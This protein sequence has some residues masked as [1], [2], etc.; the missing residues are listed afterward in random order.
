MTEI[1]YEQAKVHLCSYG[2]AVHCE[3]F[4]QYKK[5][6]DSDHSKFFLDRGCVIMEDEYDYNGRH[7][8]DYKVHQ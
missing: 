7:Y 1:T 4:R 2:T 8:I 3:V 6:H 5:W